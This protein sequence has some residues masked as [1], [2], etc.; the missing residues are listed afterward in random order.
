MLTATSQ[1]RGSR[2]PVRGRYQAVAGRLDA[3]LQVESDIHHITGA[4]HSPDL[5]TG[6]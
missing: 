3:A 1:E 4:M 5:A 2:L 6:Q